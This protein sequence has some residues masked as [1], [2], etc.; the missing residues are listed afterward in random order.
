[1][2]IINFI[3]FQIFF[4]LY[5]AGLQPKLH[6][7]YPPISYPV[8]RGTPN[9]SSLLEWDHSIEWDVADYRKL[10][11]KRDHFFLIFTF[12]HFVLVIF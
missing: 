2:H 10:V 6:E 12:I 11:R 4:R 3:M 9:I 7:M 5:N 8:S 1:M